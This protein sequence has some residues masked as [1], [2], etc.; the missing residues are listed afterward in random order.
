MQTKDFSEARKNRDRQ[1]NGRFYFSVKTT[2][3][4]C[5]P[6]CP[7]ALEAEENVF[8]LKNIFEAL[9]LG[10]RPCVSCRPDIFIED[11]FGDCH[12]IPIVNKALALICDGYL[13]F[14]SLSD[15]AAKLSV[16]DRYLRKLFVAHLGIPPVK[17]SR[18]F[19]TL[20]AQKLLLTSN[21]KITDI[22]FASG[23]GSLR[24]FNDVF[25][26]ILGKT[27]KTVRAE[28]ESGQLTSCNTL[29]LRYGP[30]FDF[31]SRLAEL[32]QTGANEKNGVISQ[33]CYRREFQTDHTSG[34]LVVT[35]SRSMPAL[36][37]KIICGD[38]R[39]YMEI[40]YKI[41]RLFNLDAYPLCKQDHPPNAG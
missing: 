29:L 33:G 26:A 24:Q 4:F 14:Y 9:A 28:S 5:C 31:R 17:I 30:G 12:T 35:E 21:S 22:A 25:K 15:L 11:Y 6:S 38:I 37:L 10:L 2:G 32:E 19:N 20:F 40:Y 18:Y 39:C 1:Y 16:S 3:T 7:A 27:P 41:R 36:E 13:G 8:Y 23:F 34:H